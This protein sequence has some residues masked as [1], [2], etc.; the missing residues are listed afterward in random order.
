MHRART[1]IEKLQKSEKE[2]SISNTLGRVKEIIW[3]NIING[4]NEI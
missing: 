3:K 2:S 1:L 4:M